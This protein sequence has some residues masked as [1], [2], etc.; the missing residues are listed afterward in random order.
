MPKRT[1]QSANIAAMNAESFKALIDLQRLSIENSVAIKHIL[2]DQFVEQIIVGEIEIHQLSEMNKSL[3]AIASSLKQGSPAISSSTVVNNS[4]SSTAAVVKSKED[5]N[6]AQATEDKMISLLTNI[7][8][9]TRGGGGD[10]KEVKDPISGIGLGGFATAIAV[11]LGGIVGALR[12]QLKAIGYFANVL[13]PASVKKAVTSFVVGLSM[14]FDL[15]KASLTEKFSSF[16]KFFDPVFDAVRMAFSMFKDSKLGKIVGELFIWIDKVFEPIKSV[17]SAFKDFFA[18][19]GNKAITSIFSI[20]DDIGKYIGKFTSVISDSGKI[21][22]K[23]FF[24][25]TVVM[26]IW[27]TVKGA[28][29]GFEKEGYVGAISGAI[30]GFFNSLI[31]GPV[32]MI[33]D[34]AAWV[35]GVFGFDKAK[36][37]LESFNLE[38]MFSDFVDAIFHPIDTFKKILG[39]IVGIFDGLKDFTI[40]EI[41]FTIPVINK[42]VAV[43]PFKPFASGAPSSD[44]TSSS[45]TAQ[46]SS[47]PAPTIAAPIANGVI[48]AQAVTDTSSKVSAMKEQTGGGSVTTVI[49]PSVNNNTK[50]TQVA[51]IEAPVRSSDSS[52]DRYL[53]ARS[54]Y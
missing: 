20:F 9:N 22:G 45:S 37:A 33:K 28:M 17:V 51:K 36:Q 39:S 5:K 13:S 16:V 40:P 54:V 41:G 14:T 48:S 6:E 35:M 25:F 47:N 2:S 1:T 52:L 4:N 23:L 30:K 50:Q 44:T 53:S 49:A 12:G 11:A 19:P 42:K 26:T 46:I 3:K 31:F 10:A 29:E 15:I 38:K 21:F 7:E 24:P 8:K 32:D 27:D 34:A 43:G 18:G